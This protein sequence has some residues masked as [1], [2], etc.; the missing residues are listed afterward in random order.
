MRTNRLTCSVPSDSGEVGDGG[1][2]DRAALNAL[3]DVDV[4]RQVDLLRVV[5]LDQELMGIRT[6]DKILE[7][8]THSGDVITTFGAICLK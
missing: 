4:L 2:E 5:E 8:A 1:V 3:H 7:D 6:Q